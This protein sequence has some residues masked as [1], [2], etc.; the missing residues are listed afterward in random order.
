MSGPS[1]EIQFAQKLAGNEVTTRDKALKKLKKWL[2]GRVSMSPEEM[3]RLWKGLYYCFWMS[4]KPLIQEE[5]SEKISQLFD[6]D[7]EW[8][9]LDR[10]RLDKFLMLSRRMLRGSLKYL[11][12][13]GW[14]P[15]PAYMKI[16]REEIL[17][18]PTGN[19]LGFRLHFIEI[20]FEE[21]AKVGG[22]DF[23]LCDTFLEAFLSILAFGK[24][25]RIRDHVVQHVFHHLIKQSDIALAYEA[26][27]RGEL[28]SDAE[29]S[30]EGEEEEDIEMEDEEREEGIQKECG[31][32]GPLDPRA[33]K[34]SISLNQLILNFSHVGDLLFEY[35]SKKQV[36]KVNRECLYSLSKEYKSVSEGSY[37]FA[38]EDNEEELHQ[39]K[40]DLDEVD[41]FKL[42]A[43]ETASTL[44]DIQ[45]N[46]REK[47]IL[48]KLIKGKEFERQES[49]GD[50]EEEELMDDEEEESSGEEEEVANEV[51]LGSEDS[52][53]EDNDMPND[54]EEEDGTD[55]LDEDGNTEEDLVSEASLEEEEDSGD[56][57]KEI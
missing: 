11:Y 14:T 24:E 1:I 21:V 7:R 31:E 55:S 34:V 35:G 41:V 5:L 18:K 28:D 19:D 48:G 45:Q 2:R 36:K 49:N 25:S 4:D 10:W 53:S 43:N 3:L 26:F 37:P 30:D 47:K 54:E 32:E 46:Y 23:E 6:P 12:D 56:D 51:D 38:I 44:K 15:L 33:G 27:K 29:E 9:G 17:E 39:M 13:Q 50:A 52:F 16:I 40:K 8:F 42:A 22:R 20:F 57:D